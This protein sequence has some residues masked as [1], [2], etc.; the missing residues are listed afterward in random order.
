MS[1]V[2]GQVVADYQNYLEEEWVAQLRK[3]YKVKVDNK[4][5]KKLKD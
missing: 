4:V 3:K 2:R 1:D 5:L